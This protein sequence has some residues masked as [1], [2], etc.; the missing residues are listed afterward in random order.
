MNLTPTPSTPESIAKNFSS[1]GIRTLIKGALRLLT[2]LDDFDD[3]YGDGGREQ[4][5][6]ARAELLEE[7]ALYT[8]AHA[9]SVAT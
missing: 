2:Q 4:R 9:V 1:E 3:Q 8:A 6:E 7:L 5:A